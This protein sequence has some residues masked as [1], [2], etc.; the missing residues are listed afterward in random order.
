MT[1][2]KCDVC[3][4]K[5]DKVNVMIECSGCYFK[6]WRKETENRKQEI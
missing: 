6:G 5:H 1:K 2:Y 4:K 3:S